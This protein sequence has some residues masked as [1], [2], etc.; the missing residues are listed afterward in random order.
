MIKTLKIKTLLLFNI[1]TISIFLII[2]LLFPL[3]TTPT[4]FCL[5]PRNIDYI[6][7]VFLMHFDHADMAHLGSNLTPL[8]ILSSLI[9]I[10]K[11]I[12]FLTTFFVLSFILSGSMLWLIGQGGCHIGVSV[13]VFSLWGFIVTQGI[14]TKSIKDISTG[15]VVGFLYVS[16]IYGLSPFQEGVSWDGHLYGLITGIIIASLL[17]K[18]KVKNKSF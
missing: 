14:F 7:G 2:E 3:F 8:L 9:I 18:Q 10:K 11:N 4:M 15:L 16:F 6:T 17:K 13:T 12:K 5:I 1:F